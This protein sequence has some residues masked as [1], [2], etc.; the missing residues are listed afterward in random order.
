MSS[1][2]NSSFPQFIKI[3]RRKSDPVYI[4]IAY[5]FIQAVQLGLLEENTKIPGSRTLSKELKVHR[6]TIVAAIEELQSQGW[7]KTK[8]SVG[9]FAINP[10][11]KTSREKRYYTNKALQKKAEFGFRKSFILDSPNQRS[12]CQYRFTTG[13]P[14]YRII[15]T[16]ELGRFYSSALKRKNVIKNIPDYLTGGNLFFKEQLSF[17]INATRGF[18]ISKDNLI[19]A[20]SKQILLYILTQLLIQTGDTILVASFSYPFSNMV[21]QQAGAMIKTI[22]MDEEGIKVDFIRKNFKKG[23][24]KCVYLAPQHQNPTT[25]CLS[26]NRKSALLKLADDYSFIVI[27]DDSNYE[28]TFD[29]SAGVPL[30]KMNHSGNVVYLG[31]FGRFLTPGFQTD[32][33]IG[34][35]DF[36]EEAQKYLTIFGDL[37]V[38]KEQAIAEMIYEG[39]IHRYRRKALNIYQSRRNYFSQLIQT[40]FANA[41]HYNIPKGG[42]A[43][44]LQFNNPF[45]LYQLTEKCKERG[46][47]IP[48]A[49]LF[50]S[51]EITALRLGFGHFNE[52]EMTA[53]IE[54]LKEGYEEIWAK[55]HI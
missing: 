43:F 48:T 8:P 1:P 9:T 53:A 28:L 11:I 23:D 3:D 2:V 17:Y 30:I 39:D 19:N 15:K 26:E 52:E 55:L 18:H 29:N 38:V 42:L 32:F 22:P 49:C 40:S 10:N 41:I 50:Q 35:K 37:D 51:R 6:K 16:N 36:I 13:E 5:Q 20:R 21:F 24:I 25:I 54:I 45:S 27:E 33:M 31:S 14:D 4:Q 47:F 44:W 7:I 46:L 12:Q 34:P